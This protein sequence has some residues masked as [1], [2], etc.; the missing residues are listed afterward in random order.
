MLKLTCWAVNWHTVTSA[1]SA[2]A[3]FSQGTG[4]KGLTQIRVPRKAP[5][6]W[7]LHLIAT[8]LISPRRKKKNQHSWIS[9]YHKITLSCITTKH[10]LLNSLNYWALNVLNTLRKYLLLE[11]L[12]TVKLKAIN[13]LPTSITEKMV[14]PKKTA[15]ESGGAFFVGWSV[16]GCFYRILEG[17]WVELV[18]LKATIHVLKTYPTKL[19]GFFFCRWGNITM[20]WHFSKTRRSKWP[21]W[22]FSH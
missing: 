22:L 15:L 17:K 3:V 18:F 20:N 19:L 7:S 4:R 14:S 9:Q 8:S 2:T 10:S 12:F 13:F 16:G 6:L 11:W 21:V 5:A 1:S